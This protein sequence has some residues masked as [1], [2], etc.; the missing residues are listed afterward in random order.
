MS[1]ILSEER[2][3]QLRQE[4]EDLFGKIFNEEVLDIS[5]IDETVMNKA[6]KIFE[7][8][9]PGVNFKTILCE[10]FLEKITNN[11]NEFV[12]EPELMEDSGVDFIHQN[13]TFESTSC[14]EM[15][16]Y[17]AYTQKYIKEIQPNKEKG[18]KRKRNFDSFQY[19]IQKQEKNEGKQLSLSLEDL[20]DDL[21]NF[22]FKFRKK[23][24]CWT[25]NNLRKIAEIVIELNQNCKFNMLQLLGETVQD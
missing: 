10:Y 20:R 18:Q 4:D 2:I 11:N 1:D 9:C 15:P 5:N 25:D 19:I 14:D 6:K 21:N 12:N 7:V 16:I 8:K 17:D 24:E 23:Y 22:F 13:V 3:N